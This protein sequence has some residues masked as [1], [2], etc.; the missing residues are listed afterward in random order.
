[1]TRVSL[2]NSPL[3]LGFDQIEQSLDRMSKSASDGYPPYNI[4][5][6]GP[7]RLRISLAVAGFTASDLSVRVEGNQ[8]VVAGAHGEGDEGRVFLH[9]GIASRQFRR[10]FLL[11]DGLE[12]VD[13]SMR[14][15][16]L[17][18]DLQEPAAVEQVKSVTIRDL[19]QTASQTGDD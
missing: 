3:L 17:H 15:G 5:R 6:L 4:E 12:V 11:A 10:N 7:D 14:H 9:R 19:E 2:F 13:A 18:I 16:L 1:M 8:L